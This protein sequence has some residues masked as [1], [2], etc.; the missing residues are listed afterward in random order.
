MGFFPP[1]QQTAAV[2]GQQ[3]GVL[4]RVRRVVHDVHGK[5]A[6]K[7]ACSLL[8]LPCRIVPKAAHYSG[9]AGHHLILCAASRQ[10]VE[11][12]PRD[13]RFP[14]PWQH[15]QIAL[16][17]IYLKQV[18]VIEHRFQVAPLHGLSSSCPRATTISSSSR[19]T[20]IIPSMA[21]VGSSQEMPKI[22][23]TNKSSKARFLMTVFI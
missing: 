22:R 10:G 9:D 1:W 14:L 5:R 20:A 16:P 6:E 13:I 15:L 12:C 11:R 7:V 19:I 8:A 17:F 4:R 21:Q 3:D 18:E 2:P 23:P